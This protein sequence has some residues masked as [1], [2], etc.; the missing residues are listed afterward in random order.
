MV[1]SSLKN[2]SLRFYIKVACCC[3][4]AF[5]FT[6]NE[7]L[8]QTNSDSLLSASSLKTMSLDDLMNV[9]VTSVSNRPQSI[10]K[11]P[12]A[13]QV[14]TGEDIRR[15]GAIRLPEAIRLA[16]NL[17]SARGSAQDFAI[18][19]R[20]F[21]GLPSAGGILANKLLVM[22]DGR[23]IYTPILGGVYWDVQ[24]IML[25]DVDRIEVVSGP[26]GTLWGANAMNGVVNIVSKSAEKT[27][28]LYAAHTV[29]NYLN[30][31]T[32][33][34]YGFK[35]SDNTFMR[36][37]AQH[38]D[39]G[40]SINADTSMH[41]QWNLFQQGFRLD[42]IPSEN[43]TLT[44]QGDIYTGIGNDGKELSETNGQNALTRYT[45]AFNDKSD[46]R[47]Q[48][49]ID[50]N[51]RGTPNDITDIT[52]YELNT[53]EIDVRHR[54]AI[55]DR[56]NILW[57]TTY[58]LRE[59][60]TV[61]TDNTVFLPQNNRMPLYSGF[62]Q[63]EIQ[64]IPEKLKFTIGSK[65][66]HNIY[67]GV[68]YQPSV[69]LAS[70]IS[71]HQT[72]WAAVSRAVRVPSRLDADITV[73]DGLNFT[74]EKVVAYEMGYRTR[75]FENLSFSFATFYN[76]YSDLRSLDLNPNFAGKFP[77]V[78]TNSQRAESWG[79]EVF[80]TYVPVKNWKIR[81]GYSYFDVEI[82]QTTPYAL[83]FSEEFEA[84]DA[85]HTIRLQSLVTLPKDFQ[86]DATF[87]YNSQLEKQNSTDRVPPFH[88]LDLRLAKHYKN[89][90]LSIVGQNLIKDLNTEVGSI[91]I[92]RSIYGRI[93]CTF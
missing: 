68:E 39:H 38:F 48:M 6:S 43:K 40:S 37:Y 42:Y 19:A 1:F 16:S 9:E 14:L 47:V 51:W 84:V 83:A 50:R 25:H 70:S 65:I 87:R 76:H 92:P 49:Y 64:L 4:A 22:N 74:T 60:K 67:T 41:D 15:S 46:I 71:D 36:V 35:L 66:S 29:G 57:G 72:L 88:S 7:V 5:S 63:N 44:V 56:Q 82:W 54:F 78:I 45:Y 11:T 20:G 93:A 18:T 26:G 90:E 79:A 2:Y 81:G 52:Q 55:S 10:S 91:K 80:G 73:V 12:S 62:I 75:P 23:S 59:D 24:N 53:Y 13:L 28:G 3:I 8:A 27:Q 33:A 85:N 86:F 34:R 32:E 89:V 21:N 77:T 69:R 17:Q 30:S 61:I 58:Q 31:N